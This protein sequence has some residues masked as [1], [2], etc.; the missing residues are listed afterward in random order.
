M[1]R[2]VMVESDKKSRNW[3]IRTAVLV[4]VLAPFVRI[5]S[6]SIKN[7]NVTTGYTLEAQKPS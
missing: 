2:L 4:T 7:K 1:L 3:G 5:I 6:R